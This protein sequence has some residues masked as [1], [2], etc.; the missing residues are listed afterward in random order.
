MRIPDLFFHFFR[1]TPPCGLWTARLSPQAHVLPAKGLSPTKLF[2]MADEDV[3]KR[4]QFGTRFLTD[5]SQ[6]YEHNAWY[7]I[8]QVLILN[9]GSTPGHFTLSV[10]LT[11]SETV[12]YS[13]AISDH[14]IC[15]PRLQGKQKQYNTRT[16]HNSW[17]CGYSLLVPQFMVVAVWR[18]TTSRMLIVSC[19]PQGQRGVGCR[20]GAGCPGTGGREL[21]TYFALGRTRWIGLLFWGGSRIFFTGASNLGVRRCHFRGL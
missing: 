6:V 16:Y 18:E 17:R 2:K 11:G 20:T 13:P 12:V 5:P 19:D 8:T 4:P 14:F 1:P 9:C 15:V 10:K 7:A 21:F 3:S